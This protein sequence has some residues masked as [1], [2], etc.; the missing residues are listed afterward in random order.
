[1]NAKVSRK[2]MFAPWLSLPVVLFSYLAAW[3]RLPAAIAI[4][5]TFSGRPV[6]FISRTGFLLFTVLTLLLVL[7]VCTWRLS[8]QTSVNPARW[9]LRYYFTVIVMVLI[10]FG[11][12]IY[13]L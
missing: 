2:L 9:L 7:L 10:Y 12:L 8:K 1:M 5:F 13:N 6:T 3:W 11:I 4:H